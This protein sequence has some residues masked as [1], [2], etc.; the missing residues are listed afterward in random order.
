MLTI[1]NPHLLP[2]DMGET[3]LS[4]V[5]AVNEC[6]LTFVKTKAEPTRQILIVLTKRNY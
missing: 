1:R 2:P 5:Q 4:S 3:K 6:Q